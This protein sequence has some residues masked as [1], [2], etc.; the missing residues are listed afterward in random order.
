[1]NRKMSWLSVILFCILLVTGAC[2]K[3]APTPTPTPTP[4][5]APS[6]TPTPTPA[7]APLYPKPSIMTTSGI[8]V[9][10]S[11][12]IMVGAVSEGILKKFDIRLRLLPT[13]GLGRLDTAR[14]GLTD[15]AVE[16]AGIVFAQEGLYDYAAPN[17]GPQK[18]RAVYIN[19]QSSGAA[20]ATRADSGITNFSDL[21][22]KKYPYIVGNPGQNA[23]LAGFLAW[24][25]LTYDDV[26]KI[27][28]SSTTA[29]YDGLLDGSLNAAYLDTMAPVAYQM[30]TGPHGLRWFPMPA[31][32]KEGWARFNKH[33]VMGTPFM[34]KN[35]AGLS[36]E[37]PIPLCTYASPSYYAYEGI[38]DDAKAYWLTK[39]I[40]ESYDV[41]KD[42]T[43]S[44]EGYKLETGMKMPCVIPWHSAS[45]KYLKEVGAWTDRHEKNQG[46]LLERQEK[47]GQLWFEAMA[48]ATDK[49]ISAKDYPAFWEKKRA[50]V[51]PEYYKEIK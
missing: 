7:P 14:T 51:F 44:V 18:V 19:E 38:I 29:M 17:W 39:A 22:G 45:I 27:E 47:L 8:S 26:I 36:A 30:E 3:A 6:P 5:P 12:Y 41:Y 31:E 10:T 9:G 50:E 4:A 1:M 34:C 37:K 25:N 49:K 40:A 16:H 11:T 28:V 42:T 43:P 48:A 33:N 46:P 20:L 15:A 32:D 23:N 2:T 13:V 21:K 35:G 24:G